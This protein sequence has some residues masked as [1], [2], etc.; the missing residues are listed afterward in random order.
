MTINNINGLKANLELKQSQSE[1]GVNQKEDDISIFEF[2]EE[3]RENALE[4]ESNKQQKPSDDIKPAKSKNISAKEFIDKIFDNNIKKA[5]QKQKLKELEETFQKQKIKQIK[6]DIEKAF[7]Y[8]EKETDLTVEDYEKMFPIVN[9]GIIC[10]VER[11]TTIEFQEHDKAMDKMEEEYLKNH[12][13]PEN[14]SSN[15]LNIFGNPEHAKWAKEK[16]EYMDAQ[17]TIYRESHPEYNKQAQ[18][19]DNQMKKAMVM[20]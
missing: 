5:S 2:I 14:S 10:T 8:V 3:A 19:Y 9:K 17:E 13:E 7:Q 4:V 12:P 20:A 16:Q 18:A 11:P 15:P 6:K 1:E